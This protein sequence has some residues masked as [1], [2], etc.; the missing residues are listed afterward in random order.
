[1]GRESEG[2]GEECE[3]SIRAVGE[4][5]GRVRGMCEHK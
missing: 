5:R 3:G 1:M 4:R 2:E